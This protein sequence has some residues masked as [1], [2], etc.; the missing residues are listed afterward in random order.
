MLLVI[1]VGNTDT[2]IGIYN[3]KELVKDWRIRTVNT[4]T[5]DELKISAA[6]SFPALFCLW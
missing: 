5:E 2:V 6:L 1:D 4:I 3:G